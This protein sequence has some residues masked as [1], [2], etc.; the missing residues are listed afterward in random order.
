MTYPLLFL[1]LILIDLPTLA[2]MTR[3]ERL[4]IKCNHPKAAC[5]RRWLATSMWQLARDLLP[6]EAIRDGQNR[7]LYCSMWAYGDE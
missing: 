7:I 1:S 4:Y 2:A 6:Y 5:K 3:V